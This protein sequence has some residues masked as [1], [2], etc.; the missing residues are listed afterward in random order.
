MTLIACP[1]PFGRPRGCRR[2][3]AAGGGLAAA[4]THLGFPR[5]GPTGR[6]S[7]ASSVGRLDVR[8]AWREA[9][10]HAVSA[11]RAR[12][13][14]APLRAAARP[15]AWASPRLAATVLRPSAWGFSRR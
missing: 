8:R 12:P 1:G 2:G 9:L 15:W 6:P 3:D 10:P 7:A 4:V 13:R 14:R 5:G 11:R